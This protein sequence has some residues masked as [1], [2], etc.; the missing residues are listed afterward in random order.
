MSHA[1]PRPPQ[2]LGA[3]PG[4]AL[5]A[6][7]GFFAGGEMPKLN[8][9]IWNPLRKDSRTLIVFTLSRLLSPYFPLVALLSAFT[10]GA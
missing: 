1:W 10:A 2:G 9:S 7:F 6:G 8:S 4:S 5:A 3:E